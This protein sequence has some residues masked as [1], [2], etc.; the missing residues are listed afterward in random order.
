MS[1]AFVKDND[2]EHVINE[3]CGINFVIYDVTGKTP[4]TIEWE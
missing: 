1:R 2:L 3:V 4:A